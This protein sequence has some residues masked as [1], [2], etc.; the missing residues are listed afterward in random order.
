MIDYFNNISNLGGEFQ[1]SL[2]W[3]GENSRESE[4]GAFRA[5]R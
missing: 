2:P 3:V 4:G 1:E 5:A